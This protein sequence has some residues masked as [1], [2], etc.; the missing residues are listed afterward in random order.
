M[1]DD[2]GL[3]C[4]VGIPLWLTDSGLPLSG[5]GGLFSNLELFCA[6]LTICCLGPR[7]KLGVGNKEAPFSQAILTS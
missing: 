4:C 3:L 1:P 5:W 7:S 2:S 6:P